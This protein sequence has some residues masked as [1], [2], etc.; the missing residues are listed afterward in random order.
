MTLRLHRKNISSWVLIS[1]DI[2]PAVSEK[3]CY[4]VEAVFEKACYRGA[5]KALVSLVIPTNAS[6]WALI[7]CWLCFPSFFSMV[8]PILKLYKPSFH[9]QP[10]KNWMNDPNGPMRYKGL[11][12]MFYQHN[13]KGAIWSNNSIVWGHS[14]SKDLVNWLSLQHALIPSESHDIN[15]CWSGFDPCIVLGETVTNL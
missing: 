6:T 3:A 2:V 8:L 13:P 1:G 14:I 7:G 11:Y 4:P 5:Y 10:H 15:G 9:F 12:H